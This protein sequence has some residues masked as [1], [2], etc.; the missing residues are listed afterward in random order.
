M[1]STSAPNPAT[2]R[3]SRRIFGI[4][5]AII[6]ALIAGFFVFASLYTEYLWF[7][8]VGFE[9]FSPPSGSPRR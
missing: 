9:E 1:T 6:A 5:L 7:D 3:T 8:Q 4:S 2:P